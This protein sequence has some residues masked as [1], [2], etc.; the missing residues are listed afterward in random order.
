MRTVQRDAMTKSIDGIAFD[1]KKGTCYDEPY[2]NVSSGSAHYFCP[3]VAFGSL[4]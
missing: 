3:S 1:M 2:I 4:D